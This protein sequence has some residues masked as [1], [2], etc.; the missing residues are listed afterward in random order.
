MLFVNSSNSYCIEFYFRLCASLLEVFKRYLKQF[1]DIL[2]EKVGSVWA[3]VCVCVCVCTH[4][5]VCEYE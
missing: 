1:A 2:N 4:L 3:C 5:I